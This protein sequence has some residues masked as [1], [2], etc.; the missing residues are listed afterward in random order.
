MNPS[1]LTRN[2]NN[3]NKMNK[4]KAALHTKSENPAPQWRQ[5]LDKSSALDAA[6]AAAAAAAAS[7]FDSRASKKKKEAEDDLVR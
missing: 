2:V 6:A 1:D 5:M 7:H 3:N 4:M